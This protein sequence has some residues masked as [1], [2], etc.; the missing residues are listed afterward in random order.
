M[1]RI[2]S[3]GSVKAI[4]IDKKEVMEQLHKVARDALRE[5]PEIEEIRLFGSLARGEETGLSDIDILII[6]ETDVE[7]PIE[8]AKPYFFYF[9]EMLPLALDLIVATREEQETVK[10]IIGENIIL[11]KR[12]QS[13]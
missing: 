9:S 5:F 8:R 10:K 13:Y 1:R 6:A 2:V 7:N 4:Y 3:S 12:P 11:A